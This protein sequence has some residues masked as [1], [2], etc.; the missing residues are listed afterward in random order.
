MEADP[1]WEHYQAGD[2]LV[3]LDVGPSTV[4]VVSDQGAW[5]ETFGAEL[6]HKA[7][8]LRR[9]Q[10][11]LDRQHRAGSPACFDDAGRHRNGGCDWRV[12]SRQARRTKVGIH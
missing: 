3:G 2:Q 1:G 5:K 8:E 7:K 6:D 9:L 12:R 10:R 4:A 11:R